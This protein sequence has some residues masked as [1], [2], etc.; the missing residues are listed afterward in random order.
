VTIW[1]AFLHV[2]VAVITLLLFECNYMGR[3][4]THVSLRFCARDSIN[5]V[6]RHIPVMKCLNS[7][8]VF[9]LRLDWSRKE[10]Q[11]FWPVR[12]PDLNLLDFSCGDISKPNPCQYCLRYRKSGVE[13]NNLQLRYRLRLQF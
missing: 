3:W 11:A 10:T 8:T 13:F 9:I 6:L 2:L 12:S 5:T 1:Q 7:V 4:R